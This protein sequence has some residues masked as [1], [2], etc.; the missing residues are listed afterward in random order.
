[1]SCWILENIK[2]CIYFIWKDETSKENDP[3]WELIAVVEYLNNNERKAVDP[4]NW[5]LFEKFMSEFTPQAPKTGGL[6]QLIFIESKLEY[7]GT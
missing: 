4:Y 1:M 3:W 2:N 7:L 6:T 5:N